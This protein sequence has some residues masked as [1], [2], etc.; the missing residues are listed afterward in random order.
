[1][2]T[3]KKY[4]RKVIFIL[5]G[6][7]IAWTVLTIWVEYYG[8]SKEVFV[9]SNSSSHEALIV[10]NPDPIYNFDE[11]ICVNFANGLSNQNCYVKVATVKAAKKDTLDYDLYVFCANTYNWAPDWLV[12]DFIEKHADIKGKKVVAITLGSGSTE[13]AMM[14]LEKSINSRQA[15]LLDSKTY[16]LLKPNDEK[17][18]EEKNVA[19]AIDMAEKFGSEMGIRINHP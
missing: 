10:Y 15:K 8:D 2:Q 3:M 11:Q 12:K 16:W 18:M 13:Q 5:I 7:S 1:M 9:G 6:I 19:V 17:R 14:L 4:L